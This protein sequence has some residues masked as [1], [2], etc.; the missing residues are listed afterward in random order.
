MILHR[1]SGQRCQYDTN[2]ISLRIRPSDRTRR[3]R[4]T[5]RAARADATAGLHTDIQIGLEI[6]PNK[7]EAST[8]FASPKA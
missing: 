7:K 2:A 1:T 4:M 6:E 3:S 8:D 5:E